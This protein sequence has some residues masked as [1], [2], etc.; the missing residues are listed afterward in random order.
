[1]S[2]ALTPN[3]P[4]PEKACLPPK[5]YYRGILLSAMYAGYNDGPKNSFNVQLVV[6]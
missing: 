3:R 1:M 4:A 6:L 5:L 2:F